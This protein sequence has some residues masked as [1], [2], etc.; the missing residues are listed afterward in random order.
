MDCLQNFD[1]RVDEMGEGEEEGHRREE[2]R[3]MLGV[4]VK[5]VTEIRRVCE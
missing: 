4:Q 3:R 5:E 1:V 2:L